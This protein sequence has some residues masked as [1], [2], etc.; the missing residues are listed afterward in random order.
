[1]DG[2]SPSTATVFPVTPENIMR[3]WPH[4]EPLLKRALR[5]VETH[6]A[7]DVRR[8]VLGEQAHLWLQWDNQI[9]AFVVTEFVTYPKGTWL[10][11][12][13]AATAPECEMNNAMF[14]DV[15]S[16]WKDTNNCRGFE[17]IGRMGWLRRFPEAR[18]V[19]VV[20]RTTT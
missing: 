16:A 17:I 10:R 1:M 14:E 20:L 8:M 7:A 6:D 3:L 13:L 4:W 12:W 15:L 2:A 18:F 19:G 9:E 11:L 5:D